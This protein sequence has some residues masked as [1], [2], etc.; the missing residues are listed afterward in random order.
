MQRFWTTTILAVSILAGSCLAQETRASITGRVT[1][2]S[3]AVIPKA[4]VT[5]TNV[6]TNVSASS[7]TNEAGAYDIPYLLPGTY[8]VSAEVQ[9]FKRFVREG[10]ELRVNDRVSVS[11]TLEVGNVAESVEVQGQATLLA[12]ET[13]STGMTVGQR[14]VT[15]LPVVGG[16]AYYMARLSAGISVLDRGNGQNLFDAGS[17]T[18]TIVVNGTRS[19]S[20]E[21]T[22]DGAP[23]MYRNSLAFG[24]PQDLVQEFKTNTA[25]YDAS[26]GHAAGA[27]TNVFIKAGTNQ[28]HGTGNYY[29]SRVRARPWFQNNFLFDPSTGPIT[30]QKIAQA[31][32]G[33]LHLHWGG[34]LT[35]PVVIPHLYDG[36]NKTFFSFGYEGVKVSR[37]TTFTGTVPTPEEIRGDFSA[38]LKLGSQ[39]Q[40]YDPATIAPAA[41]GRFSRQPLS[42]NIVPASRIDSIA[43]KLLSFYPPPNS[44]G[45]ADGL[46]NYFRIGLDHRRWNS[47][48]GRVD[49][50]FSPS[51]RVFVRFNTNT[52][53]NEAQSMPTI[54]SG[55]VGKRPGYGFVFDDVYVFNAGLLLNAR[56][57]LTTQR[58]SSV[59][60]SSGFDLAS[61]GL[62]AGLL[63]EIQ[64]KGTPAGIAF[65]EVVTDGG[66]YSNLGSAGGSFSSVYYQTFSGTL[67]KVRGS[68]SLRFG[69]EFRVLRENGYSFGNVAPRF[70]FANSWARGPLDT[71][72]AAPVGQGLASMLLGV[73]TGGRVDI[74]ASLAEQSTFTAAFIQDD[75]KITP[76]LTLNIG[77]RYEYE[78]PTTER[79][80]RSLRGFAFDAAN[81][82]QAAAQAKYAL[83]PIPQ[84]APDKFRVLGGLTFAGVDGQPRALWTT[85]K[86]NFAPRVGLAFQL[87]PRTVIRSGY[88]IFYDLL[89]VD[90]Q[91]ANQ[92]G[93]SQSTTLLPSLDNG[94]T[95]QATLRNPFPSGLQLPSGASGGLKTFLG[96]GISFFNE[97]P[98]NPYMQRWS[99]SVQ[100]E[101]P[102]KTVVDVSYVG[103]RGNKLAATRQLTPIPEG[104]LST[105]PLRDQATIDFL[106]A[107]VPNP[108]AGL[109]E[110]AGTSLSANLVARSQLLRPYSEFTGITVALP[111]GYSYYHSLQVMVEKRPTRGLTLQSSWTWSKFMEATSYRNETDPVPEKLISNQ[112]FPQRFIFSPIY[113]LPIGKD[114]PLWSSAGRLADLFVGGWQV[115]GWYEAETGPALG[116]GNALFIG[117]IHDIPLPVDQRKAQRWFN[118]NAGFV[119][120]SRQQLGSNIITFPSR[121]NDVR[122][123]GINNFDLAISKYFRLR[124][125]WRLQF[126]M[127]SFNA[128]NHVEF[129]T[130]N[131][132]PT[133]SAFGTVTAEN[134]HGQ[135]QVTFALKLLF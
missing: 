109:P 26:M 56:Y 42:G 99:F 11:F 66:T 4:K 118:I 134:G 63:S 93:F 127:E 101:L 3:E 55:T 23:N 25:G 81:P 119:R 14:H 36:R 87:T 52:W 83:N 71:S 67:T 129:A 62:P 10:V 104:Y 6:A 28:L 88:G 114:K 7:E 18:T 80:N 115:Q 126:R 50:N 97:F 38:L 96:R 125:G 31:T 117:S 112:D 75:W 15:E 1:D 123:D 47:Y 133:S 16:N 43:T 68:H 105:S 34:T 76:R 46:Q 90:R 116:F 59:P 124:E 40:I 2:A 58:P 33:W 85:D 103:N 135:R 24:P 130:P 41:G 48:L 77:L 49:H 57:G 54:A 29:D 12:T 20:S 95:F 22:L 107:Q 32:P 94:L 121:F 89:G 17:A 82:V 72:P 9:G 60:F 120:D 132:N 8:R 39:Y 113:E 86:N 37:Q 61:L 30:P 100:R 44:P 78:G 98:R 5:A 73:P 111:A 131:T 91:S 108:F 79:Y 64:A 13:A 122:A 27:V 69:G 106:S 128:L 102:A 70:E 53:L 74:N 19:G 65:P 21:V 110:F 45:T 35:G 92:G 51:H 84:L